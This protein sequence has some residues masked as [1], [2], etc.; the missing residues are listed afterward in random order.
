LRNLESR[1][2]PQRPLEGILLYPTIGVTLNH[3][4]VLQGLRVRIATLDLSQYW[5]RIERQLLTLVRESA[6][7]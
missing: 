5:D 1:Q 2:P 7:A 4:Y 3:A 6:A